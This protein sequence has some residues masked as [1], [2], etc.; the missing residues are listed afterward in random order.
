M[1]S[2]AE[3]WTARDA[4]QS[5]PVDPAGLQRLV[6]DVVPGGA[7]R[8]GRRLRGGIE[9]AINALDL[10]D[11]NGRMHRAVLK[12]MSKPAPGGHSEWAGLEAARAVDAPTPEPIGFDPDGGWFGV[13]GLV[14]TRLAGRAGWT[15]AATPATLRQ[16]AGV[17]AA[18]HD[19]DTVGFQRAVPPWRRPRP[20]KLSRFDARLWTAVTE[21]APKLATTPTVL[22][23][24][25]LHP[26]NVLWQ[27]GRVS[28]ILD[29]EDAALGAPAQD[30]AVTRI[31]L[32]ATYGA[33]AADHL[34]H[35]YVAE[36]GRPLDDLPVWDLVLALSMRRHADIWAGFL[37]RAGFRDAT[38]QRVSDCARRFAERAIRAAGLPLA[39]PA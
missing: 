1:D 28:A 23:H 2:P 27:R 14:M 10:V 37:Q 11:R 24:R 32:A 16:L 38:R 17:L 20:P 36:T 6:A 18:I 22:V 8:I 26:G 3:W 9:S 31:G 4:F 12:R 19:V 35:A 15:H 39:A 34:L 33:T 29:W 13:P 21:L 5:S 30:L 7:A 25:D